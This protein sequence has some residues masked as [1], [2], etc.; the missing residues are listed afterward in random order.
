M[1]GEQLAWWADQPLTL[2][3]NLAG[4]CATNT[5]PFYSCSLAHSTQMWQLHTTRST[6]ALLPVL[7]R[8]ARQLHTLP[9]LLRST[10][11]ASTQYLSLARFYHSTILLAAQNITLTNSNHQLFVL[12]CVMW[13]WTDKKGSVVKYL[14]FGHIIKKRDKIGATLPWAFFGKRSN[15]YCLF[16]MTLMLI[17]PECHNTPHLLAPLE[18]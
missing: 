1:A 17:L 9:N 5:L 13:L 6:L 3:A 15:N 4:R 11:T 16:L 8:S 18:N 10:L 14:C 12:P 7:L 2:A